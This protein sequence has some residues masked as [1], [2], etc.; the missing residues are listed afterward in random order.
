MRTVF[1]LFLAWLASAAGAQTVARVNAQHH[2]KDIP[3]GN[4]SG[5][6]PLGDDRFAVVSDKGDD[7]FFVF[8]IDI[9][10]VDGDIRRVENLGF[11]P[12]GLPNRDAEGIAYVPASHRVLVCGESD[13]RIYAYDTTGLRLDAS[14]GGEGLAFEQVPWQRRLRGNYG[15]ESLTY[16]AGTHSVW[17]CNENLGD[18]I[19]L[20]QYD[21]D[22]HAGALRL[23]MLDKAEAPHPGRLYAH[24]VSE[25]CALG[26]STLL[27]LER[28]FYVPEGKVGAW[29][30]CKLYS[31]SPYLQA[32][33][34]EKRLVYSWRTR[35]SLLSWEL[36][37]YEGM[38]VA[39][40]LSGGRV[41]LLLVSDSQNQYGGVLRDWFKTIVLK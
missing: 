28:E 38:C 4:Y 18:T 10:T 32:E 13:N 22:G 33:R 21:E 36:A 39:R 15:L 31:V 25:L 3:A 19:Y 14:S 12:S 6:C 2:Y 7:G 1:L 27:V 37:N 24:G 34:V 23:Y 35:L 30:Q 26:D 20:Q 40:R 11:R 16:D 5:I 17:T 41:V 9:D 8:R 29:V